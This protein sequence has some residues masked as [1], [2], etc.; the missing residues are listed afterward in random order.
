MEKYEEPNLK[1][2]E[3]RY[4][5]DMKKIWVLCIPV[6]MLLWIIG[7][8]LWRQN[9]IDE[10]V[11]FFF[12]PA[13]ITREPIVVISKWL[14][15]YGMAVISATLVLYLLVSQKIKTLDAPLEI[16]LFTICSLGISGIAGDLLKEV[17]ARARPIV[18]YGS[19]VLVVLSQ[20][21]SPAMPS[22]HA[23]KSIALVVP[24]LLLVS[25]SNNIHKAIKIIIAVVALGVC[26]S[27]IVLGAHYV[28]DVI[29]GIGIGFIGL[30]FT[31]LFA[32][33]ILKQVK[34]EKL[35][36]M[37]KVWGVLLLLLTFIFLVI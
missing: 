26:F 24:F 36:F 25:G 4:S 7:L 9:G 6:G 16:Y 32:N 29:A 35:P 5:P 17:F 21:V 11:L 31:M 15:S 19:D 30:P 18:A 28:S 14:S 20:S 1:L 8:I 22:G 3:C 37:S 2:G 23:T 34:L 33:M 12:N 10:T 13:R 27:R